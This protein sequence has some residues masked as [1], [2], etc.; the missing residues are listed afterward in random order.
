MLW[1]LTRKGIA[2]RKAGRNNQ[3]VWFICLL[4]LNTAGILPILYLLF[5]QNKST[6]SNV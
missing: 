2:M 4:L 6:S 3:K 1:E 5:F